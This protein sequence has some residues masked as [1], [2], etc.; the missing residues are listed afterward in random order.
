MAFREDLKL[1]MN[2]AGTEGK[3]VTTNIIFGVLQRSKFSCTSFGQ[4]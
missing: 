2:T 1:L 3:P 4:Y